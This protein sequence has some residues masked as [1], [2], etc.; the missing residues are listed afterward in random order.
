MC[1]VVAGTTLFY[2]DPAARLL[3]LNPQALV[4]GAARVEAGDAENGSAAR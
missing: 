3:A 2:V 1:G 4:A